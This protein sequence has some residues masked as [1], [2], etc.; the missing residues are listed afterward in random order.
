MIFGIVVQVCRIDGISLSLL[1]R[2][3]MDVSPRL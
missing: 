1:S 3:F 2:S